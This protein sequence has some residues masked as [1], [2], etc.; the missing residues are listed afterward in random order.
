MLYMSWF[1]YQLF[2]ISYGCILCFIIVT[3]QPI[4]FFFL[5]FAIVGSSGNSLPGQPSI[6][7]FIRWQQWFRSQARSVV[8]FFNFFFISFLENFQINLFFFCLICFWFLV[9]LNIFWLVL[10]QHTRFWGVVLCFS[11]IQNL[12]LP[13]MTP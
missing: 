5:F 9:F 3:E 1:V 11:L 2:R 10:C 6:Y 8:F 12:L 4:I 13:V 7:T